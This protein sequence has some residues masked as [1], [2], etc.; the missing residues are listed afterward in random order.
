MTKQTSI[1]PASVTSHRPTTTTTARSRHPGFVEIEKCDRAHARGYS[2]NAYTK[3]ALA[4]R[5]K[6]QLLRELSMNIR[7]LSDLGL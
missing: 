6:T 7:L 4:Q 2:R 1:D 5:S 3:I